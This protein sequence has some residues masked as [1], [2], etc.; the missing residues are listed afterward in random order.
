MQQLLAAIDCTDAKSTTGGIIVYSTCSV[1]VEENE[2]VVQYALS[3]RY[4]RIVETG[5]ALGNPGYT[6]YME[7]RFHPKM[8]ETR[9]FYPHVHNMDGFYVAKLQKYQNGARTIDAEDSDEEEEEN[10]SNDGEEFEDQDDEIVEE[11]GKAQAEDDEGS[12]EGQ[13]EEEE[14]EEEE[15]EES[16]PEPEP[17]PVP[18]PAVKTK[19]A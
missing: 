11:E 18:V 3:K 6:R 8:A 4:V 19:A 9:R 10:V 1:A 12:E 14:S 13:E 17:V 2:Q 7:R 16:E 15:E 5:L